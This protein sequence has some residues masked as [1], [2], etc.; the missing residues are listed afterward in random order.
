MLGILYD[1][2]HCDTLTLYRILMKDNVPNRNNSKFYILLTVHLDVM[3]VNNQPDTLFSK[4]IYSYFYTSICFEQQV[5]IIRRLSLY[6]YTIWYNIVWCV[7]VCRA[8]RQT[9]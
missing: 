7:S 6:Q 8:G 5:L 9:L 3:L 2:A 1:H 4:C